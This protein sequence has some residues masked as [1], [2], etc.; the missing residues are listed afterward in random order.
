MKAQKPLSQMFL[1]D[2]TILKAEK[3][4]AQSFA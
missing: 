3:S 2:A 1:L 4:Q